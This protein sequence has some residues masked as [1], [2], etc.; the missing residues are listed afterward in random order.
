MKT[1][2]DAEKIARGLGTKRRGRVSACAGHFGALQLVAELRA[3]FP[4]QA[5]DS[6]GVILT[7]RGGGS[8][9]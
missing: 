7:V 4:A 3:R 8:T 9:G 1:R 2:L 6:R 5:R